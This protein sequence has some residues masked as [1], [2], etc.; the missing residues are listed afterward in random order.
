MTEDKII[1]RLNESWKR[2]SS[3]FRAIGEQDG[4]K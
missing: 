2:T 3:S 1:K 4:S